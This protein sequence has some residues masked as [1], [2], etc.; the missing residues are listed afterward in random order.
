[1][2]KTKLALGAVLSLALVCGGLAVAQVPKDNV[3]ATSI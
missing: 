1:M 2:K 3:T